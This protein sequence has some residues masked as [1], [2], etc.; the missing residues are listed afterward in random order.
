MKSP[1]RPRSLTIALAA[2]AASA[3]LVSTCWAAPVELTWTSWRTDDIEP[4]NQIIA[5]FQKTQPNIRIKFQPIK[6]T[7]YDAQLRIALQGGVGADI[8][9][10]RA[11]GPGRAVFEGKHLVP[12]N[13][14][15]PDLK[16]FTRDALTAWTA[17]DGKTI[18]GVPVNAVSAGYIYNKKIFAKYRLS[19]P[20]TWDEFVEI[21]KVL[22]KNGVTPLA[23]G[24]KTAWPVV[25]SLG[26]FN[27]GPNIYGG[28]PAR[29]KLLKGE[30]TFLDPPFLKAFQVLHA[31]QPYFP[32]AFVGI[33]YPDT[34]QMFA[35]EQAAIF[36]SGSW[37]VHYFRRVNPELE[38]GI[39]APPAQK[40][41]D[42]RWVALT[43][44]AA[45]GLNA[46]SKHP[47]EVIEFLNWATT[48]QF[49]ELVA[50][51]LLGF[52]A[53]APAQGTASSDPLMAEWR[54]WFGPK[55]ENTTYQTCWEL[56]N[57]KEPSCYTLM[58]EAMVDMFAGKLTPE[59]A[60]RHVHNGLA[61][62][63]A[64]FKKK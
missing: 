46:A 25:I 39:F 57:D 43:P 12:L 55:L 42:R 52:F 1:T 4:I 59:Q 20:S 34:Q 50:N 53:Y 61:G 36:P 27:A 49:G 17:A 19:P 28:E 38:F 26:Y 41:G 58:K 48:K 63:Y 44:D 32:D 7:E 5:E 9:H 11:F 13:D 30:L 23:T 16:N 51:K 60:A 45:L 24:T 31:L 15:V 62:W 21:L 10:V 22:K 54:S 2:L 64:P 3:C 14:K 8:I 56:L 6:S 37:D 18:Y 33:S 29:L 35:T 40:K 47:Q